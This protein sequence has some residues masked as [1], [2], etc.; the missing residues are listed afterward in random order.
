MVNIKRSAVSKA[1]H[2]EGGLARDGSYAAQFERPDPP[3]VNLAL[4]WPAI[5]TL[6]LDF[7]GI[8][9]AFAL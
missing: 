5:D 2:L 3:D 8:P 9:P 7:H 4:D 6:R 1:R